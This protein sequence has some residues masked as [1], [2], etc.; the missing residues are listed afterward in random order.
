MDRTPLSN[1]GF[2][3]EIQAGI[4]ELGYEL[5]TSVQAECI[6]HLREGS[7]IAV[8]SPRGSGQSLAVGA[9]AMEKLD[10]ESEETQC[11]ILCPDRERANRLIEEFSI[12]GRQVEGLVLGVLHD[13]TTN[14]RR[15]EILEQRPH[16]LVSTPEPIGALLDA[17]ALDLEPVRFVALFD[18]DHLAQQSR[19]LEHFIDETDDGK[20]FAIFCGKRTKSAENLIDQLTQD[21]L[22]VTIEPTIETDP[23]IQE[24]LF[25]LGAFTK[26]YALPRIL[27]FYDLHRGIMSCNTERSTREAG[28]ILEKSGYAIRYLTLDASD[29]EMDE[30]RRAYGENEIDFIVTSHSENWLFEFQ[31]PTSIVHFDVPIEPEDYAYKTRGAEKAFLLV[32]PRDQERIESL[33][34]ARKGALPRAESLYL[35]NDQSSAGLRMYQDLLQRLKKD[36][37][38]RRAGVIET[39]LAQGYPLMEITRALLDRAMESGG[40]DHPGGHEKK[41][42]KR[43]GGRNQKNHP[44]SKNGASQRSDDSNMQR[45]SINVGYD[46]S[47]RPNHV[48]GAILGET[49]LTAESVGAI[50]ISD[51]KCLV[52]VQ[53]AHADLIVE[54]LNHTEINGIA[55]QAE[56]APS[57]GGRGKSGRGGQRR[58]SRQGRG[59]RGSRSKSSGNSGASHAE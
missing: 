51:K 32:T 36:S 59:R 4:K 10:L 42:G 8:F 21:Y 25:D 27:D 34:R 28:S 38:N 11:L 49:G 55:I 30:A 2:T 20:Q 17:E 41:G 15:E 29:D 54:R 24:L 6:N 37:Q 50:E 12:L 7:D 35:A 56:H 33:E 23:S 52:E 13:Q 3:P 14:E 45:I 26:E 40:G 53:K 5:A 16:V 47:I 19:R 9:V 31:E 18:A 44:Q 39:L 58:G 57:G 46:H 48:V 43:D 1:F 22:E